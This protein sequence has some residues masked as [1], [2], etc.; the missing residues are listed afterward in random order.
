[1]SEE[2][3]KFEQRPTEEEEREK[4]KE[5]KD[6]EPSTPG[7]RERVGWLKRLKR[8]ADNAMKPDLGASK[9]AAEGKIASKAT[10]RKRQG[11]VKPTSTVVGN[12]F[13]TRTTRRKGKGKGTAKATLKSADHTPSTG[14]GNEEREESSVS[15]T[16][17][18]DESGERPP[19]ISKILSSKDVSLA[20]CKEMS[21][22]MNTSQPGP[23]F[24][25]SKKSPKRKRTFKATPLVVVKPTTKVVG[26]RVSTRTTRQNGK[27][28][29]RPKPHPEAPT[30]RRVQGVT[31]RRR[32]K[33]AASATPTMT[34]R[35]SSG[36]PR[37]RKNIRARILRRL[38]AKTCPRA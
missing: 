7:S 6:Q 5:E 4:K 26:N 17:D 29:E 16:N 19:K 32:S 31:T 21:K 1:M 28:K 2:H 25:A 11:V 3:T 15:N 37:Y 12:G 36:R 14:G 13:S 20:E 8:T 27:G 24:E 23:L 22:D 18:D 30:T 38:N 35:A 33:R 10:P 9:K 34:M